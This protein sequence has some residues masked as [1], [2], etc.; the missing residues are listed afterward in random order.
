[1][2]T[3]IVNKELLRL[4][5]SNKEIKTIMLNFKLLDVIMQHSRSVFEESKELYIKLVAII[6]NESL[7]W[8]TTLKEFIILNEANY[9]EVAAMFNKYKDVPVPARAD[10]KINGNDL[11]SI[12]VPPCKKIGILLDKCYRLIMFQPELNI[13]EKLLEYCQNEKRKFIES[14]I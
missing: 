9:P 6:K 1:V 13:K 5:F 8:E 12:G 3:D 4:K 7:D 11:L 2:E 10:L 14:K